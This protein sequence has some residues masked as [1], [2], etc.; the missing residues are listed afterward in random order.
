M[1]LADPSSGFPFYFTTLS[2]LAVT[3]DFGLV[4]PTATPPILAADPTPTTFSGTPAGVVG[5][6]PFTIALAGGAG[7]LVVTGL[8]SNGPTASL[9]ANAVPEPTTLT[10]SGIGLVLVGLASWYR[11]GSSST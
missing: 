6:F 4:Y 1:G 2:N 3:A 8:E 11:S 9:T 10:L 7:D 5:K